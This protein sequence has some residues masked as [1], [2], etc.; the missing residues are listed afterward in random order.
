MPTNATIDLATY[1]GAL[2]AR[3][4]LLGL[5]DGA[6][7][8]LRVSVRFEGSVPVLAVLVTTKSDEVLPSSVNDVPVQV[9]ELASRRES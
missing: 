9:Y 6:P 1:R 2:H 3:D 4:V 5:L 8:V 7:W